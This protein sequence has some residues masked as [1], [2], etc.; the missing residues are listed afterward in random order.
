MSG[1]DLAAVQRI[2]RHQDPR[3]TTEFYGH[4]G[5]SYLKRQMEHLSFRPLADGTRPPS[6]TTQT[7]PQSPL[8][9]RV[10][11]RSRRFPPPQAPRLGLL[12]GCY[13]TPHQPP[14]QAPTAES[15]CRTVVLRAGLNSCRGREE[16]LNLRPFGPEPNALPDCATPRFVHAGYAKDPLS[17]QTFPRRAPSGAPRRTRRSQTSTTNK[18]MVSS[19]TTMRSG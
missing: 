2:M 10:A 12:P 17:S 8:T 16:D 9:R 5:T 13:P 18:P 6:A 11:L 1:A 15:G 3:T 7:K 19:R 4:L 14:Q